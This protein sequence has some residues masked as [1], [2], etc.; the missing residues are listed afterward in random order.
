MIIYSNKEVLCNSR[1]SKLSCPTNQNISAN[2][3]S[4]KIL[5]IV[6][7]CQLF[8]LVCLDLHFFRSKQV[9]WLGPLTAEVKHAIGKLH[10]WLSGRLVA[11]KTLE[12]SRF[13]GLFI[14]L[15]RTTVGWSKKFLT[16]IN[17][18]RPGLPIT[19][20]SK[21]NLK[22]ISK[23]FQPTWSQSPANLQ[24]ISGQSPANLQPI[25]SQSPANFQAI[26]S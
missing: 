13:M 3:F 23:T 19:K 26:S 5:D 15:H 1:R 12:K 21:A 17:T 11:Q 25:F 20:L 18:I 22:N 9:I 6:E 16:N 10:V 8:S 14:Y 7:S 24:S 4:Y 2:T